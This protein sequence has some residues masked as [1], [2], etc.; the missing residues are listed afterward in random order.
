M[1][2]IQVN[3]LRQNE[4]T[5]TLY[6]VD[7]NF[8]NLVSSISLFG[9]LEPLIVFPI[10]D[11]TGYYQVVSGN[12]RL[13]AAIKLGLEEIPCVV[14]EPVELTES[15]VS[16]HQEYREKQPS[17]IIRELRILDEEFGLRQGARGKDPKIQKARD[18]KASL[19]KEHNKSTINRLRQ[20]DKKVREL[21]GDNTE[22]YSQ[23]MNELD[24]SRNISGSL[25]KVEAILERS[26][27]ENIAAN[28]SLVNGVGY[29][30][31]KGSCDKMP[32]VEDGTIATIVTSPPYFQLREYHNGIEKSAQLGQEE[33]VEE[34]VENLACVFD[35]AKRVLKHDGSLF[36]NIADNVQRGRKLGVPYKFVSAMMERGWILNDTIIWS[37]VNPM[38][39]TN[40]RTVASHEYIYHFVKTVEFYYDRS[41]IKDMN[42]GPHQMTYGNPKGQPALRSN[43]TF[44]GHT[45]ISCTPNNHDLRVACKEKGMSL[46]HSATFPKEIPLVA[47]LCT[48]RP[49]DLV[50]DMFSGTG[51]TGQVA[52]EQNREYV[53]FELSSVYLKFSEIRLTELTNKLNPILTAA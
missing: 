24:S 39:Q 28:L 9:V 6:R 29:T 18:Y 26:R 16:A 14:I 42:F 49:G 10:Q 43:W 51:T 34:F 4:L 20:F 52:V 12:R 25:T 2:N 45:L 47:I 40:K 13:N 23:Y 3:Q 15:R 48:S 41:W 11:E 46:S 37:K 22:E 44:D 50:M 19:I 5:T 7:S 38:Y 53:G 30:I 8:E 36:V 32:E 21:V 35:E 17:D 27:N 31:H 1:K 33:T